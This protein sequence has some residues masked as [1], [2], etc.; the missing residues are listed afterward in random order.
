MHACHG[1]VG[2]VLAIACLVR[3]L[4][5]RDAY[6]GIVGISSL[7]VVSTSRGGAPTPA[8]LAPVSLAV[9]HDAASRRTPTRHA[10]MRPSLARGA[11]VAS[12]R[13]A[14]TSGLR[15]MAMGRR[16][17]RMPDV[18]FEVVP[19]TRTPMGLHAVVRH[20]AV[21]PRRPHAYGRAAFRDARLD[22]IPK[23]VGTT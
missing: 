6:V 12:I 17:S 13:H 19:R 15:V 11:V 22:G 10:S 16:T 5:I 3:T 4:A 9:R 2:D 21:G 1:R 20:V 18:A 7:R 14:P 23:T 8:L